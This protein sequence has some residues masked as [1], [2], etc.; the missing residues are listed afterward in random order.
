MSQRTAFQRARHYLWYRPVTPTL[1][2]VLAPFSGFFLV[3][4]LGLV[5]LLLDLAITKGTVGDPQVIREWA[6]RHVEHTDLAGIARMAETH[7][8]LGLQGLAIRT[9]HS[10]PGSFF[11]SIV[12]TYPDLRNNFIYLITLVI[13]IM[14]AALAYSLV[15]FLQKRTAAAAAIDAITRLR[16]SVHTHAY[17]L[18]S[19]TLRQVSKGPLIG[20][21]MRAL[22]TLQDGLYGWFIRTAHEPCNLAWLLLFLFLVDSVHGIPWTSLALLGVM[23]LYWI[24]SSAISAAARKAERRDALRATEG[25]MLL[26]ESLSLHRLVKTFGM[27]QYSRSRLERLLHRQGQAVQ[28]R[29]YWQFLSR[30]GR[31]ALIAILGPLLA[32]AVVGNILD[33]SLRFLPIALMLLTLTCIFLILQRWYVAWHQVA[34][35]QSA[36]KGLFDLLD[37]ET[38]VKQV[39][40]AEFLPPLAQKLD[41]VNVTVVAPGTDDVLLDQLSLRVATGEHV[42]MV[43]DERARLTIAYLLPRLIDP[44]QGEVRVDDKPLPWATLESVRN[45]VGL[46]LQDDLIFNDTLANN[47]G[48]GNESYTLPRIIEAAKAAHAHNFIMKLPGGYETM[49]GELG[50][51]LTVSQQFRI[52]LARAILRDPTIMVIEEPAQGLTD[53]DKAWFDDTLARFLQNR[54]TILL[55]TRLSTLRKADRVIML[56]QGAVLDEGTDAELIRRC[57]R[58]KHWQYMQFHQFQDEVE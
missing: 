50:E 41:L 42:A 49:I 56:F 39:V 32:L 20:S 48:C 10:V 13:G 33:Q 30:H 22:D 35:A 18:G 26:M 24:L 11:Q 23:T 51:S 14:L 17:R 54:T 6:A 52:A 15:T 7:Q 45:Q 57:A 8:G 34:K 4:I 55:P 5:G 40:G 37:Q 43:G 36:A 29:W 1:S 21:T 31:W 16:R 25:Q 58:Y 19:L 44:D 46:V 3:M 28:S 27:E 53:E 2:L 47:I 38:D 9:H 12:D